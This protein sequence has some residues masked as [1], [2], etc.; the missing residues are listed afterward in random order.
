MVLVSS[1]IIIITLTLITLSATQLAVMQEKLAGNHLRAFERRLTLNPSAAAAAVIAGD[2]SAAS[3]WLD[4]TKRPLS[5]EPLDSGPATNAGIHIRAAREWDI[6]MLWENTLHP[7]GLYH[8]HDGDATTPTPSAP[9]NRVYFGYTNGH[10]GGATTPSLFSASEAHTPLNLPAMIMTVSPANRIAAPQRYWVIFNPGPPVLATLYTR[11]AT[12]ELD[13]NPV[14][15]THTANGSIDKHSTYGTCGYPLNSAADHGGIGGNG[16]ESIVQDTTAAAANDALQSHCGHGDCPHTIDAQLLD[17]QTIINH[18]LSAANTQHWNRAQPT[19]T[20]QPQGNANHYPLLYVN[21][22]LQLSA[23]ESYG[24]I[25]VAGNVTLNAGARLHGLLIATGGITGLAPTAGS[26][27][28]IHGAV[29]AGGNVTL[30]N[31]FIRGNG[32]HVLRALGSLPPLVIPW[33]LLS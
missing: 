12:I 6:H 7:A 23:G 18:L 2:I 28:G 17:P 11:G 5:A 26:G 29:I 4:I 24:L 14:S 15:A 25:L 10:P 20:F 9:G 16:L 3:P 32:C 19:G 8:D 13:N 33:N 21:D 31:A 27:T 1:L 22:N 30:T